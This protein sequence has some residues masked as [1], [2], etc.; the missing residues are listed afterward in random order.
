MFVQFL[1]PELLECYFCLPCLK[2][3]RGGF[4]F[5]FGISRPRNHV[6]RKMFCLASHFSKAPHNKLSEFLSTPF[7]YSF[8]LFLYSHGNLFLSLVLIIFSSSWSVKFGI[9]IH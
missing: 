9:V 1:L 3:H 7:K 2:Y 6:A 5:G 8:L 4:G